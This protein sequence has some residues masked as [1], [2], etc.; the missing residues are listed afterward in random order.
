[1]PKSSIASPNPERLQVPQR[2]G[3]RLDVLHQRAL[4]DLE[5]DR[6]RVGTRLGKH[7]S[8]QAGQAGTGELAG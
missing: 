7:V 2:G 5:A 8:D 6:G 4:G 1:V 3:G